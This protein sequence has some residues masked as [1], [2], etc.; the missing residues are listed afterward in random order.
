MSARGYARPTKLL[1]NPLTEA[2]NYCAGRLVA[3]CTEL[4][5]PRE[6]LGKE[7]MKPGEM[8]QNYKLMRDDP[9]AWRKLLTDRGPGR[10]GGLCG[11]DGTA[12]GQGRRRGAGPAPGAAG[13]GWE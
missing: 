6:P 9:V 8:L 5:K 3:T 7:R 1:P 4:A 2:I 12:G 13:L 10:G 11:R